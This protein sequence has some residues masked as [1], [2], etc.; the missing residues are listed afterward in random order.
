M[1]PLTALSRGVLRSA[2]RLLAPG[3]RRGS[4][5]ILIFHRVLPE[6]D[7]LL[8]DE[9]DAT[10]FTA[11]MRVVRELFNVLSLSEAIERLGNGS[12]PPR[13]ACITFD[14]GYADN[15]EVAA[16]ILHAQALPATF[17]IATGFIGGRAMWNDIVIETVRRVPARFD[18]SELGYG[19]LECAD[20]RARARAI[21]GL[22]SQLKYLEPLERLRRIGQIQ[23]LAGVQIPT[24]L[25]MTEAQLRRLAGYGM[26][27]GAHTV[28]HPILSSVDARIARTEISASRVELERILARP[29][30]LFAYPNG[31]PGKDFG[32]E[33]VAMVRELGFA[34]AVS[35]GWGRASATTDVLQL[36]RIAPWDRTSWRY[37]ARMI[38]AYAQSGEGRG[39]GLSAAVQGRP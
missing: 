35:T 22:L 34:G 29:V 8:A 19:I 14:D 23:Q 7:P 10:R 38:R 21:D 2:A 1:K 3:G 12:L 17:F 36:P 18:L 13:A 27:I 25:M 37:G 39:P 16:P 28:N 4:L 32:N 5:V 11:Q 33:H 26:E 6:P 30:R 31:R 15:V 20:V 9:P 24:D